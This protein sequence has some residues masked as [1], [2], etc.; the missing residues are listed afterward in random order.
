MA[1]R[2]AGD[3]PHRRALMVE[4]N[5]WVS[6][7]ACCSVAWAQLTRRTKSVNE[8]HPALWSLRSCITATRVPT[9]VMGRNRVR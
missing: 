4:T 5:V 2:V 3:K 1:R 6:T 9:P 7:M 8:P